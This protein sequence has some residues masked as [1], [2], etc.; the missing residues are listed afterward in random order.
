MQTNKQTKNRFAR[1]PRGTKWPSFFPIAQAVCLI[2]KYCLCCASLSCVQPFVALSGSSVHGI[3]QQEY[4]SGALF[5]TP[6]IFQIQVSKPTSFKSPALAAMFFTTHATWEDL[7][8]WFIHFN[9]SGLGADCYHVPSTLG[10]QSL[11]IRCQPFKFC[12]CFCRSRM[13]FIC[14][15]HKIYRFCCYCLS[16]RVK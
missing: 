10:W 1:K 4:W 2:Y 12:F 15:C 8:L 9:F 5:P 13:N 6:G 14:V 7:Q 11:T 16:L 3:Y